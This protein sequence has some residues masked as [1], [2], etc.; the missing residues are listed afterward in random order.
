MGTISEQWK[1]LVDLRAGLRLPVT[2]IVGALLCYGFFP[3][4]FVRIVAPKFRAYLTADR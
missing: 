1:Q 2:L 4:S 3:Q